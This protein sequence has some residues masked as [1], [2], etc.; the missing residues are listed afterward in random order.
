MAAAVNTI[1]IC[2]FNQSGYCKYREKCRK[3]H[4][5]EI[6]SKDKC[7]E[8]SC[9]LRHPRPC[10]F[11]MNFGRCKFGTDCLYLHIE[12]SSQIEEDIRS[13]KVQLSEV[14]TKLIDLEKLI[15]KSCI[16][17]C[18]VSRETLQVCSSAIG[19]SDAAFAPPITTLLSVI[20][21]NQSISSQFGGCIPQ[22]DG[23][24]KLKDTVP[25]QCDTCQEVFEDQQHLEQH[26]E[27]YEF[28]C[29]D[30]NLCFLSQFEYDL[31]EYAEHPRT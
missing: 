29:E 24:V 8:T 19:T 9:N 20:P 6:C 12:K 10:K 3:Q 4:I 22:L 16:E 30:C 26:V 31:H 18:E 11:Y 28:A 27:K 17:S 25:I 14:K 23:C 21:S 13:I 15:R 5:T 2:Q 1:S 7:K